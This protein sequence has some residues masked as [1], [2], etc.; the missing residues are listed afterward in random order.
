MLML[1]EQRLLYFCGRLFHQFIRWQF[2]GKAQAGTH[3]EHRCQ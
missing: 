3:D 1:Q 2:P